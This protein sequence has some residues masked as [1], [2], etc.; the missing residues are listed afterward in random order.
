MCSWSCIC[1]FANASARSALTLASSRECSQS[2]SSSWSL[3]E[4]K[5][6]LVA[7]L[8][9]FC[10]STAASSRSLFMSAS[11]LSSSLTVAS[12]FSDGEAASSLSTRT[13]AAVLPRFRDRSAAADASASA[14]PASFFI[15]VNSKR[16]PVA[17]FASAW[18]Q[19]SA[20]ARAAAARPSRTRISLRSLRRLLASASNSST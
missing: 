7:R 14:S 16:M 5:S 19:S 10:V 17:R 6:L 13:Q 2:K 15:S 18:A 1:S 12:S 20:F 8:F 9:D 4:Y 11:L 3:E